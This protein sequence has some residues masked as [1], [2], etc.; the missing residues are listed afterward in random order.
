MVGMFYG[1]TAFNQDIGDWNVAKVQYMNYMF[2]GAPVFNHDIGD[3]NV[4]S[5]LYMNSMFQGA[6]AS[7]QDIGDWDVKIVRNQ[8][9]VSLNIIQYGTKVLH[10][11]GAGITLQAMTMHRNRP[12]SPLELFLLSLVFHEPL[13]VMNDQKCYCANIVSVYEW[14][15]RCSCPF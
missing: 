1:A 12:P 13:T 3:W 11:F 6:T 10:S 15:S 5:V 7:N 9:I 4:A 14:I 8:F 2:Y